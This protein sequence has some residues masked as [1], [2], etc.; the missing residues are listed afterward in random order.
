M[1]QEFG[2]TIKEN[3]PNILF[4][5]ARSYISKSAGLFLA[6]ELPNLSMPIEIRRITKDFVA[7]GTVDLFQSPRVKEILKELLENKFTVHTEVLSQTH[8][9]VMYPMPY[10]RTEPVNLVFLE[11]LDNT[12]YQDWSFHW[13]PLSQILKPH[14]YEN[15]LSSFN[16]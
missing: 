6:S 15:Y 14:F 4:S 10:F 11:D 9:A 13:I 7:K 5:A 2:T 8:L 12:K 1:Y 3:E 16:F